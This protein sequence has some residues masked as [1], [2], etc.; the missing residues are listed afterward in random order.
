M[1][2]DAAVSGWVF[3]E[4]PAKPTTTTTIRSA[5]SKAPLQK[6]SLPKMYLTLFLTWC[7][8]SG[9]FWGGTVGTGF[10]YQ[11]PAS[12]LQHNYPEQSSG[13]PSGNGFTN[14]R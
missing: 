12:A 1:A 4:T 11:F 13:G 7:C 8:C 3:G 10:L 9:C 14:R 6:A 5:R 2:W